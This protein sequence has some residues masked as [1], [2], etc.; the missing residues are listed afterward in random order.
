VATE[1]AARR[2][3]ITHVPPW[4]DPEVVLRE[5]ATTYDGPL[6]LAVPG[7]TYEV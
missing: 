2:L 7:K 4:H 1:A 5:A 3:L 6:G